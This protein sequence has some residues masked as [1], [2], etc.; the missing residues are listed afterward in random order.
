MSIQGKEKLFSHD[1]AQCM[2]LSC[3]LKTAPKDLKIE[4]SWVLL[5]HIFHH[6]LNRTLSVPGN[7]NMVKIFLVEFYMYIESSKIVLWIKYQIKIKI[8]LIKL[9]TFY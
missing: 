1:W 8:D 9:N 4:D 2:V 7:Y 5:H 6:Q 3:K